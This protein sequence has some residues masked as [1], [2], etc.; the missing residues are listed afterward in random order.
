MLLREVCFEASV[1]R[2]SIMEVANQ[3]Q[4]SQMTFRL[5]KISEVATEYTTAV[6]YYELALACENL[7]SFVAN[8]LPI[9]S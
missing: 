8:I 6:H 1:L 4:S 7:A 3:L 2:L 9:S 5:A